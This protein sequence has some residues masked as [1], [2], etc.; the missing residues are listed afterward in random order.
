MLMR[1][2]QI[3]T[4][5]GKQWKRERTGDS[6]AVPSVLGVERAHGRCDKGLRECVR[7]AG[8]SVEEE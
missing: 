3:G 2:V 8:R 1:N 4:T 5:C 7:D 6:T